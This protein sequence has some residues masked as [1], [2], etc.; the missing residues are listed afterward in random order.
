MIHAYN[1]QY[2]DT[3]QTKL[4]EM[5][6][7]AV[8]TENIPI[9]TFA[10]RFLSSHICIAFEK[11]DPVFVLG[12]SAN[13]LLAILL[14]KTPKN[15]ETSDF[16]SPEYW[17]GYVL[18]YAQ[19]YLNKPYK[20]LLSVFPCGKLINEYFPYHEMDIS[21]SLELFTARLPVVSKLKEFRK[22]KNL[23]QNE[24]SLLSGIPVRT[25]KSY[26]QGTADISKAQAETLYS[27]SETLGCSIEDL[28]K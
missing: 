8:L 22:R 25:I 27:L 18:A 12:K 3:I 24:L 26:E 23:S 20:L 28:I 21:K 6:E 19:W 4:A 9:D 13:E 17:V 1:K 16:A 14:D 2:L 15:I 10:E 5:F 7:L 11:A